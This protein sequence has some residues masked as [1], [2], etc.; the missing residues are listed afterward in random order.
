MGHY[1]VGKTSITTHINDDKMNKMQGKTSMK[2]LLIT[3]I[4]G[5]LTL[6]PAQAQTGNLL[7][8]PSFEGDQFT[9]V[10]VAPTGD[11][12]FNVP[13]PWQGGVVTTPG[14]A[15]WQNL[16]PNGYP[17]FGGFVW[18]GLRSYNVGRGGG[19]FTA[20]IYQT[21]GTAPNT[22]LTGSAYVYI[23]KN[24]GASLTR[25]GIDPTGGTNPFA[26]TVVWSGYS[27]T[28]NAWQGMFVSTTAQGGSATMFLYMTQTAPGDPNQLYW[29]DAILT[30][31]GAEIVPPPAVNPPPTTQ[32]VTSNVEVNVRA[33][34]ATS[35]AK[36]GKITPNTAWTFLGTEG[37][38]TSIDF[39]G[40]RGF[41]A[42]RF[43][44]VSNG[45]PSSAPPAATGAATYT[46]DYQ[47]NVR[48]QPST[49][50]AKLSK[51]NSGQSVTLIGKSGDGQW[52]QIECGGWVMSR[53]GRLNGNYDALPVSG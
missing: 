20:W 34:A 14:L 38:F 50:G 9:T 6:M 12:F 16:V 2:K 25:I 42:S 11:F 46:P 40:Q 52:V 44:S 24:D 45:T 30:G 10:A 15:P 19:Q 49:R 1:S 13:V 17:H 33:A 36:L 47:V 43:V 53:F 51:L 41:V 22:P 37:D 5:L 21:V 31:Q 18:N 26:G 3:L 39:N 8:N 28:P 4:F 48:A 27:N 35:A 32:I 29:D 7:Q 23:E